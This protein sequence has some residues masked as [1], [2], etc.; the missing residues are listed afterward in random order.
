MSTGGTDL[1]SI[2]ARRRIAVGWAESIAR[3]G[4][5][6]TTVRHLLEASGI[7]RKVFY[8]HYGGKA[9]AFLDA[10]AAA[11]AWLTSRVCPAAAAE[12]LWTRKIATG[13]VTALEEMADRP[14]EAQLL[15]GDP[16]AAG[17]RAGYC[18]E[19]LVVRFAP[20]LGAGRRAGDASPRPERLEAALLGGLIGVVSGRMRAATERALPALAPQLVEFLLAPYVGAA[21]ARRVA[22]S[23]GEAV[24]EVGVA[25]V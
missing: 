16:L 14:C 7:S 20:A 8:R 21:E 4:Y 19:Q 2:E 9:E 13:V 5:R 11:L 24:N 25:D 23:T 3:R 17:P 1:S 22:L 15:V 6:R 18:Q 10:H 12:I